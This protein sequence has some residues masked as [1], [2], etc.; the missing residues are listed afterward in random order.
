MNQ[1][2]G[3]QIVYRFGDLIDY[4][5]LMLLLQNIL[6]DQSVQV[7]IH[8]LKNKVNVTLILR[9]D[10]FL[11]G[12]DIR[13]FYFIEEHHLP[14]GSLS[15]GGILESIE[16]LFQGMDRFIFFINNFPYDSVG[17]TSYFFDDFVSL[18]NMRLNFL[19]VL[20]HKKQLILF[21]LR[22]RI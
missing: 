1:L 7:D 21:V 8:E 11:Q 19:V 22:D 17:T 6:S 4:V 5:S 13:M 18:Q 14:I 12:N 9:F 20:T 15:V 10:Y 3:V 2:S 16:V